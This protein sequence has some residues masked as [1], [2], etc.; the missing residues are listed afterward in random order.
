MANGYGSSYTA[1]ATTTTSSLNQAAP[2]N[3]Q[4]GS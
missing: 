2:V 4:T 3:I 1:T